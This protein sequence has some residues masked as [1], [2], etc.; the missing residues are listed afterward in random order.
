SDSLFSPHEDV[1]E[2]RLDGE[3]LAMAGTGQASAPGSYRGIA[4]F[5]DSVPVPFQDVTWQLVA[6]QAEEEAFAPIAEMRNMML[7]IA[8]VL[9]LAVAAFGF[10]FSRTIT[11]PISKLTRTMEALAEGQLEM[12]VLG[13]DRPDELGAM[14]KAVEVFKR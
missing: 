6:L 3:L 5:V 2:T 8:A 9:L 14:A 7:G 4:L 10:V 1:L 11:R 13:A 12:G